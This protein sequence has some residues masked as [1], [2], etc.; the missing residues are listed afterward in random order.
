V[1]RIDPDAAC[2]A[3]KVFLEAHEASIGA[4]DPS[5]HAETR[6][7]AFDRLLNLIVMLG[8]DLIGERFASA[9]I[10][11]EPFAEGSAW[12]AEAEA[13]ARIPV[14]PLSK[15]MDRD[16][17]AGQRRMAAQIFLDFEPLL[18]PGLGRNF[19]TS[20]FLANLGDATPLLKPYRIQGMP[21]ASGPKVIVDFFIVMR[22]YW[23]AGYRGKTLAEVLTAEGPP[24]RNMDVNILNKVVRKHRLL[25]AVQ[26][27]RRDGE[28]AKA[29]DEPEIVPYAA[30]YDFEHL[31]QITRDPSK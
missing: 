6:Q 18:V 3:L 21:L 17:A 7:R 19:A 11:R 2:A 15:N 1:K 12:G 30:E 9:R 27:A 13:A 5:V 10:A 31:D 26:T 29:A 8:R 14:E 16:G 4:N 22:V 20:M 25:P 24:A 23:L 28:A